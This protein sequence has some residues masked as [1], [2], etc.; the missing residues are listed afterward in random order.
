MVLEWVVL[1][2][3]PKISF[4]RLGSS[5]SICGNEDESNLKQN[6]VLCYKK[7]WTRFKTKTGSLKLCYITAVT[8]FISSF[9]WWVESV[10]LLLYA[11]PP[12]YFNHLDHTGR[13][14]DCYDRPELALGA[15]EFVATADYCKVTAPLFVF[16]CIWVRLEW[17]GAG[18]VICL[19]LGADL[20]M[21]QLM[22]LPL[23]VSWYSKIQ[24][25]FAFLV[26]AD[27]GSFRK[28]AVKCVRVRVCV[29]VYLSILSMVWRQCTPVFFP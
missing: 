5:W 12:E 6:C 3:S 13:R 26:P 18:V 23:T 7:T 20:H 27:P 15:Y 16:D 29:C 17:W 28:R 22:L 25:G 9:H 24:I 19:E 4:V 2:L 1:R 10:L 14:V 11:V 8:M 21:T